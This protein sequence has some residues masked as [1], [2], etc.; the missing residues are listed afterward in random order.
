MKKELYMLF[1]ALLIASTAAQADNGKT[2]E[3]TPKVPFIMCQDV[4]IDDWMALLYM[5]MHPEVELKAVIVSGNGF[6]HCGPGVRNTQGLLALGWPWD[7]PVTCGKTTPLK[8]G[9]VIPPDWRRSFDNLLG[10]TLPANPFPPSTLSAVD[11][12]I[13]T[14][15]K[16]D[17]KMAILSTG[18]L[19]DLAEAF[20]TDASIIEQIDML[21]IMG[22]AVHVAGNVEIPC[23]TTIKNKCAEF[24]LYADP[25][26]ADIVFRSGVPITLVPLDACDMVLVDLPFYKQLTDNHIT[27]QAD[28]VFDAI[29]KKIDFVCSG[30]FDM[31]DP[32]AAVIATDSSVAVIEPMY[33]SI[34]ATDGET[35]A[36]LTAHPENPQDQ[37]G[38]L[39]NV[40]VAA[41]P[42]KPKEVFLNILNTY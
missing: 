28:F 10:L 19:T 25:V 34:D 37:Q 17:K 5:H 18:T 29:S 1:C 35:S 8:Y 38:S 26:A 24:N 13:E 16:S 14:V 22:G 15:H 39:M 36:C 32:L 40:C 11:L 30:L 23:Q 12:I 6:A 27:P 9:H 42:N 4:D 7:V 31:W 20:E 3:P 2:S 33:I 21:Y 41:D